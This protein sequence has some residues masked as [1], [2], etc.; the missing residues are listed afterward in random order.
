MDATDGEAFGVGRRLDRAETAVRRERH[1]TAEEVQALRRFDRRVRDI[2]DESAEARGPAARGHVVAGD[3]AGLEAVRDAY[4]ETVMA[5]QHYDEEYDDSYV[6]SLT[7]EF[8]ADLAAALTD[9]TRFNARCKQTL[10]AGVEAGLLA[11]GGLLELLTAERESLAAAADTLVPVA[12]ELA[13]LEDRTVASA[14]HGMLDA[15][16]ARLAVL[17]RK[18]ETVAEERQATLFEQRRT[19]GLP[20][21]VPDVPQY[22]YQERAF[23]YPVMAAVADCTA[24]VGRL[25]QAVDDA[26][27]TTG[28]GRERAE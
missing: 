21:D 6:E 25:R 12:A 15:H 23:D 7:A 16:A 13:D 8:S 19:G 9:G 4:T 11:R 5:V 20:T 14:P 18:C 3:T 22:V 2:D 10:Q 1:R 17:E 27:D 26:M 24:A 28:P